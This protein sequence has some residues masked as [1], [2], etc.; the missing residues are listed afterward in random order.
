[1]KKKGRESGRKISIKNKDR[2]RDP[3]NNETHRQSH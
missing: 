2:K 1:M 3:L